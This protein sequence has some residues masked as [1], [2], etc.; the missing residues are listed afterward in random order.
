[1]IASIGKRV[2]NRA[3]SVPLPAWS[4]GSGSLSAGVFKVAL[5]LR[6]GA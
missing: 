6:D 4:P 2:G 5:V 3:E 1:M